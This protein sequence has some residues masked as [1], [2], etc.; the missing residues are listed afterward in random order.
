MGVDKGK[1]HDFAI[2]W[3]EKYQDRE[4]PDSELE[5]RFASECILLGFEMD[6]GESFKAA[7]GSDAFSCAAALERKINQVQDIR[8]LGNAVFSQWR[9]FTHWACSALDR[10]WFI[11]SLSRLGELTK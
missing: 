4:T 1:I 3:L 6:C 2:R 9:Y 5:E 11:I 10:E 8:V 7:Y